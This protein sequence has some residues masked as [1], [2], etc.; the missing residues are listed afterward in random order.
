M[1]AMACVHMGVHVGGSQCVCACVYVCVFGGIN[2]G[3][4][5]FSR[6]KLSCWVA[7]LIGV[8]GALSGAPNNV[9]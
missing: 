2:E 4:C 9:G 1:F 5:T 8:V 3:S 6:A 7:A